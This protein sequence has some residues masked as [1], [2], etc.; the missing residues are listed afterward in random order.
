M[1]A[2]P[3]SPDRSRRST[4][5]TIL[6]LFVAVTVAPAAAPG[7]EPAEDFV[8]QLRA[9]GYHDMA[10]AYLDRIDTW[11]AV[12]L[13]FV[14]AAELEKAQTYIDEATSARS[15]SARDRAFAQ[16]AT[17]LESFLKSGEGPR[18]AEARSQLG[19]LQMVRGAQT[20]AAAGDDDA[21]AKKREAR[22]AF[23]NAA[24]IFDKIIDDL[25]AKLSEMQG[26]KIDADAD[27]EAAKKRDQYRFEYLIAQSDSGE[28]RLA[29]AETFDEPAKEAE[30]ELQ[31]ALERFT[32][33]SEKYAKYPVGA[34]AHASRGR[35]E[36]MLGKRKEAIE[37]FSEMIEMIDADALVEAKF[38]A[39]AG[40][41]DLLLNGEKPDHAGAI[42]VG[43][44]LLEML[45]PNNRNGQP[46]QDLRVAVA[47]AY[48][49]KKLDK[50]VKNNEQKRA[51]S[52]ARKLLLDAAKVTGTHTAATEKLMAELGLQTGDDSVAELP[53]TDDPASLE[54]AIEAARMVIKTVTEGNENL[55]TLGQSPEAEPVREAIADAKATGIIILRRGLAKIN[56]DSDAT[57][58]NEARQYLAYLLLL[59]ERLWESMVVGKFLSRQAPGTEMGLRGGLISLTSLQQ[60]I[61]GSD[62]ATADRLVREIQSLG[63]YLTMTWPNDP[64]AAS[65]SSILIRLA[66]GDGRFDDARQRIDSM[67]DSAE[68]SSL[69]RLLGQVLYNQ[70]AAIGGEGDTQQ[71]SILLTQA[72]D[73]LQTGLESIQ[74]AAD[75]AAMSA[76]VVLAKVHLKKDS[77][78]A[79]VDVLDHQTYGP[80]ALV[81]KGDSPSESFEADLHKTELRAVVG[82][83]ALGGDTDTLLERAVGILESMQESATD[84]AS[85]RA[86]VRTLQALA[87]DIG[88]QIE[89]AG[90][91]KKLQLLDAFSVLLKSISESTDDNTML[92]W[93]GMTLTSMGESI[94]PPGSS[95][96]TGQSAELLKIA[97]ATFA[98]ILSSDPSSQ[99]AIFQLGKA[100]RALGDHSGAIKQFK[101]ILKEKPAMIDAQIEAAGTYEDWAGQLVAK[102]PTLA[103]SAYG[104]AINGNPGDGIWGWGKI[105]TATM[106]NPAFADTFFEARYHIARARLLQ[107]KTAGDATIIDRAANDIQQV[108]G[109]YPDFHAPETKARFDALMRE[110]Q[111][112][113][114]KPPTGL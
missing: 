89:E 69:Y 25:K 18:V 26:A 85:K 98:R 79:A 16:A 82:K 31:K 55:K 12:P 61:T 80:V 4:W 84:E 54:E 22:R 33:L 30:G 63:D 19:K 110:I 70:S 64:A 42:E 3:H 50:D 9:A 15:V 40:W 93:V 59:D 39:G 29:I 81:A 52:E 68:K 41:I 2:T 104:Y 38:A 7:D 20:L 94:M 101:A 36:A 88:A 47:R 90:G 35:I 51:E 13:G 60:L 83:M 6:G 14:K 37:S 27:P 114:G 5:S 106:R 65:A 66:M 71:A 43:T 107:G 53:A 78:G 75:A 105:S 44:P 95:R 28:A 56:G 72:Q 58:V 102:K 76:A 46:A 67:P 11:P 34:T 8:R 48:L 74:G 91:A 17:S 24:E 112:A 109:L 103:V 21:A 32:D 113:Q 97:A 73:A 96:A 87:V 23:T 77:P 62:Q 1:L 108:A 99:T 111:I 57:S 10:I 100:Q 49:A 86:L 92:S 45:R